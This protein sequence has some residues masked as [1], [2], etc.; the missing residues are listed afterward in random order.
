MKYVHTPDGQLDRLHRGHGALAPEVVAGHEDDGQSWTDALIEAG[1]NQNA[2]GEVAEALNLEATRRAWRMTLDAIA[3]LGRALASHDSHS[4]SVA[5]ALGIA[6]DSEGSPLALADLGARFGRSKQSIGNAITR[7]K[8]SFHLA[9]AEVRRAPILRPTAPG[10]WLTPA[11]VRVRFKINAD[12]CTDLG[13]CPMRHG[14]RKFFEAGQVEAALAAK[15]IHEAAKRAE[16][17]REELQFRRRR[18]DA[19]RAPLT[20]RPSSEAPPPPP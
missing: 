3:H 7:L 4:A 14:N 11:E 8:Q 2:L 13:L 5:H 12:R 18:R 15:E 1:L 20:T 16:I 10:D 19:E 9:R 6:L 17:D